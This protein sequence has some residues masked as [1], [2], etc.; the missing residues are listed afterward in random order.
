MIT[1]YN[2]YNLLIGR[3][4]NGIMFG[5]NALLV[6]MY[7]REISPVEISGRMGTFHKLIINIGIFVAFLI[8]LQLPNEK[9]IE[10]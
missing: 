4:L 2:Y 3:T 1:N 6:P 9:M 8:G 5:V 10:E 7:I